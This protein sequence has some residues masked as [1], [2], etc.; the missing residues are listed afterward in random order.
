M[1]FAPR[2]S[3]L[4]TRAY[5]E[6]QSSHAAMMMIAAAAAKIRARFGVIASEAYTFRSVPAARRSRRTTPACSGPEEETRAARARRTCRPHRDEGDR[7]A[8]P[9]GLRRRRARID[10]LRT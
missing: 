9:R 2:E 7:C 6:G 1:T 3:R 8:R 5:G 4:A 10:T